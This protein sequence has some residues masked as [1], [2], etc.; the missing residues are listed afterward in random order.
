MSV[1]WQLV[2]LAA[3]GLVAY[4]T[5]SYLAKDRLLELLPALDERDLDTC[6]LCVY[7]AVCVGWLW[8][9]GLL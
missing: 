3:L 7:G 4:A 1:A 6:W 9:T 2:A 5:Y 8:S